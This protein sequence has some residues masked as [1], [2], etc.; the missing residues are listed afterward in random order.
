MYTLKFD[1]RTT[2]IAGIQAETTTQI[3]PNSGG[4]YYVIVPCSKVLKS[5]HR[6]VYGGSFENIR[7]ANKAAR[8]AARNGHGRVCKDCDWASTLRFIEDCQI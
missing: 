1:R 4:E 8:E 7:D 2:H 6:M 3:K 5:G